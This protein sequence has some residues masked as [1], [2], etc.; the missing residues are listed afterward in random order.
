MP[1]KNPPRESN[2]VP[3]SAREFFERFPSDDACLEHVMNVRHGH[4]L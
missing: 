4:S 3:I 1:R 2:I